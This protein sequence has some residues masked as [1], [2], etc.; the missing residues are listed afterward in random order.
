MNEHYSVYHVNLYGILCYPMV[1]GYD[2][3][4]KVHPHDTE[5]PGGV[6]GGQFGIGGLTLYL[7]KHE[8]PLTR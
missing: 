7:G 6:G 5:P 2:K 8:F 1:L 3:P 4:W